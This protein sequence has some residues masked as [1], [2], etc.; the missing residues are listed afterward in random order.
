[1][2]AQTFRKNFPEFVDS[3]PYADASIDFWTALGTS[4]LPADRWGAQ[5][6]YGLQ[7][8]VAHHL[9]IGKRDAEAAAIGGAPGEIK[10]VLTSRTVDKV[11]QSWDAGTVTLTDAG[12]WNMTSYGVRF[13][14]FAR[15]IGAGGI[16]L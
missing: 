4:L 15:M 13:L 16:Q 11:T 3:A 14:Q 1:M 10:G 5:L 9:V 12:F 6:D 2:D 7:L 8:F